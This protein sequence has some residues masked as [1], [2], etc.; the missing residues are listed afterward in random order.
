MNIAGIELEVELAVTPEEHILGLMYRD[1]LEDNGGMLFVFPKEEILS[2]WMKETRIPLS[3]AFI[4]ANGQ[5]IQIES[6][7]PYSLDAHVSRET[8][9]YALEMKECW[10]KM[11]NIKEGDTVKILLAPSEKER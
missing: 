2:F 1:K 11:H 3:I 6:M 10:F 8:V 4:K 9:K 7:K 5:I